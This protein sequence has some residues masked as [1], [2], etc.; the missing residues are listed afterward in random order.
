MQKVAEVVNARVAQVR[1]RSPRDRLVVALDFAT[2]QQAL[3]MAGRLRGQAGMFKVGKQLFTAEGP[4]LVRELV[5]GGEKVFLDLK[6]HDI[7][8]TVEGAVAA[9]VGLGATLI[10][11]HALGGP[12]MLRAAARAAVGGGAAVLAVTVLTSL[13]AAQLS[14]LGFREAPEELVLRLARMA[15]DAGLDGVVA[16]P[17]EVAALRRELGSGF[18]IVTPGVRL[19]AADR[20]DQQRIA[21]PDEAVRNGADYIVVGRPITQAADPAA[22]ARRIVAMLE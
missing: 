8:N 20:Q 15:L 2:R 10:N 14:A 19:D 16:A 9:A 11:V 7:P 1:P 12:A 5:S 13:D 3:S 17:T 4:A 18:L 22:V 21:A 6:F